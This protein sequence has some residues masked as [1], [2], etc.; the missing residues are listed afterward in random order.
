[1]DLGEI[2]LSFT[3]LSDIADSSTDA[4]KYTE[5]V[6]RMLSR[7]L[8]LQ[9][10][11]R[12]AV[13]VL[14]VLSGTI[15]ILASGDVKE[16]QKTMIF[17]T[18]NEWIARSDL[19]FDSTLFSDIDKNIATAREIQTKDAAENAF[20]SLH[21][22]RME[23][24]L[25][26]FQYTLTHK[27]DESVYGVLENI[28]IALTDCRSLVLYTRKMWPNSKQEVYT[29]IRKHYPENALRD[30]DRFEHVWQIE[31]TKMPYATKNLKQYTTISI[32][33]HAFIRNTLPAI[34]KA[35]IF[36]FSRK[37]S[38]TLL[39][40]LD[41]PPLFT[42]ELRK[43]PMR[44]KFELQYETG[45]I[46]GLNEQGVVHK[47][48]GIKMR[49]YFAEA[50][51]VHSMANL[52]NDEN[53]GSLMR[54]DESAESWRLYC[55]TTGIWKLPK[56][57]EDVAVGISFLKNSLLPIKSMVDFLGAA[58]FDWVTGEHM[59]DPESMSENDKN[60][61][62]DADS[63]VKKKQKR[64][65]QSSPSGEHSLRKLQNAITSFVESPKHIAEVLG[66]LKPLLHAPFDI[67]RNSDRLACPNGVINLQTGELLPIAKPEDFFTS[68]CATPYDP[69]VSV[70]KARHFF[71][72]FFPPEYYPDYA[73]LVF[74]LQVW[75]GYCLTGCVLLSKSLWLYGDGSNGKSKMI[76]ML[77][78][79]LGEDIHAEIPMASL[80]KGRGEN[81]DALVDA[82]DA[83][84]VTVSE[85]DENVVISEGAWKSMVSG[86]KQ[87]LKEMWKKAK[88]LFSQMKLTLFVNDLPAWQNPQD[89]SCTR[90]NI[91]IHMQKLFLDLNEDISKKKIADY[92]AQ[93]LPDCL[94]VQKDN[95]YFKNHVVGHETSF[96]RFM[97]QG[98][99][100]YYKTKSIVIPASLNAQ[101]LVQTLDKNDAVQA[102]V[103]EHLRICEGEKTSLVAILR[104]FRATTKIESITLRDKAFAALLRSAT[105]EMGP[106]W[107][108]QVIYHTMR[109]EDGNG[110]GYR[111]IT[112]SHLAV[113]I[114]KFTEVTPRHAHVID[115]EAVVKD[116]V[117]KNLQSCYGE[118]TRMRDILTHFRAIMPEMQEHITEK[119]FSNKLLNF[120]HMHTD[121]DDIVEFDKVY[122]D[123]PTKCEIY[124][125]LT[126]VDAKA[127]FLFSKYT[128]SSETSSLKSKVP[129][130]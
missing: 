102:Y 104:H 121:W 58:Q 18:F 92:R 52:L 110:K 70:D 21:R 56:V 13:D 42:M 128:S 126:F 130:S 125:N 115:R 118:T 105:L 107:T 40:T 113:G 25:L 57:N 85:S 116:Y 86:E 123:Q 17:A 68:A 34:M 24:P 38:K 81:N 111:N 19:L 59:P 3:E 93:G 15:A 45:N 98:A 84:H 37:D 39:F 51:G 9:G 20:K 60:E 122:T 108:E 35:P 89:I 16:E 55:A 1:V 78:L 28:D 71:E 75:L 127:K 11:P 112:F 29:F 88:T 5:R 8:I 23:N 46:I 12:S 99:M 94:I 27:T 119:I 32:S 10:R 124:R 95:N 101:Q 67:R 30:E 72:N 91:Y 61:C 49:A 100:A 87:C 63:P 120:V 83:R 54:Y 96:L 66:Q 74:F 7:E 79:V 6:T 22:R 77:A 117:L 106:E 14:D 33:S 4:E 50:G 82:R 73:A 97:V 114:Q 62:E 109:T 80:C 76:E 48:Y 53:I 26:V 90:R 47:M 64:L 65:V 129:E 2:P 103:M 31:N 41:A 36:S 44:A 69:D 43:M